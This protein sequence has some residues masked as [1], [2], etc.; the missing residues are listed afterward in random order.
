[1][2]R[3]LRPSDRQPAARSPAPLAHVANAGKLAAKRFWAIYRHELDGHGGARDPGRVRADGDLRAR[4]G[5]CRPSSTS[6]RSTARSWRRRRW[7]YPMGTDDAGRSVL[8][9]VV[10]GSRPSLLD[11]AARGGRCRWWSAPLIGIVAGY[12]GGCWDTVLMRFTDWFLVLPFLPLAV[13]LAVDPGLL[14]LQHR[15]RD[16]PHVVGRDRPARPE[17]GAL[18]A[19]TSVHRARPGARRQRLPADHE[20]RAARTWLP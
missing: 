6:R 3:P 12:R 19:G 5:R 7:E 11:R 14:V 17:P 9:L 13:V 10:W 4:V 8:A 2:G 15:A 18:R 1:M 20:A 16:R